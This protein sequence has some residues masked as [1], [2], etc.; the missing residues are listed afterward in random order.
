MNFVLFNKNYK[1]SSG[2][3]T[4]QTVKKVKKQAEIFIDLCYIKH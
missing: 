4:A 1:K 3:T 2:K